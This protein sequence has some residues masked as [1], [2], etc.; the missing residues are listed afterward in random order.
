MSPH[1]AR[2][3]LFL[4]FCIALTAGGIWYLIPGGPAPG[5]ISA[6]NAAGPSAPHADMQSASSDISLPLNIPGQLP[7]GSEEHLQIESM[8][9]NDPD[10]FRRNIEDMLALSVREKIPGVQLSEKEFRGLAEDI[11]IM[12]ETFAGLRETRR[13]PENAADIKVLAGRLEESSRRIQ[14]VTG[15][16]AAEFLNRL[17]TEGIDNDKPEEGDVVLEYLDPPDR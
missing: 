6:P 3:L 13:T 4:I 7:F 14:G 12:H 16:S 9:R 10:L 5:V 15:M 2:Y 1:R 11:R 8:E 17:T